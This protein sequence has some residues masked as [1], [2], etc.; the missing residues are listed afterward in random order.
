MFKIIQF[1]KEPFVQFLVIG[2]IIFALYKQFDNSEQAEFDSNITIDASTQQWIVGNFTKQFR[3]SPTRSEM[4]HLLQAHIIA[5]VKYRHALEMG[6]DDQDTIIRR[7]MLQK[8]DFLF[9]NGAAD[10]VPTEEVLLAWYAEHAGE[11]LDRETIS[12]EHLYYSPDTR[13][14]PE[15]DATMALDDLKTNATP[16]SDHFPFEVEFIDATRME[17]RHVLGP[18]FADDV[19]DAPVGKWHGPIRSGLGVHLVSVTGKQEGIPPLESVREEV[20]QDWRKAESKRILHELESELSS[21]F[22][23]KIDTNALGQFDYSEV[24]P[25]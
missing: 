20:I 7:R 12:F 16:V 23:I 2:T 18:Q 14:A 15:S 21:K 24:S 17:V 3:R 8:F 13:A 22:D 9:G 19:F 5:E 25:Q 11:Y 10:T 1:T 4:D 6:L